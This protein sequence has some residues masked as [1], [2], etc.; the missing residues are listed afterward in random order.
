MTIDRGFASVTVVSA[1]FV[2]I[3]VQSGRAAFLLSMD[4]DARW[5]SVEE[6]K[7]FKV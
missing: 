4:G 3:D 2:F 5:R 6:K 7:P 1:G